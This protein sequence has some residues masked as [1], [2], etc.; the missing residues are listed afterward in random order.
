MMVRTLI[1]T[2]GILSLMSCKDKGQKENDGTIVDREKIDI[3]FG[4]DISQVQFDHLYVV[5]DSVSYARIKQ[6]DSSKNRYA[7][8][9]KGLPDFEPIDSLSTSCYLRGREHSIEL[10]G[11]DN[12]Y[13]EPIGK[14]GIGFSLRNRGEH[15]HLGV[16]PK[17][18]Q[19]DTPY[20]SISDTVQMSLGE[21]T[22]T[23]FKAFYSPGKETALIT[24]YAFYN[25]I[26]LDSL[27]RT[28]HHK[29]SRKAFLKKS[30]NQEQLF[31]GVKSIHMTCIPP[32][33][34]RIAQ[35]MRQLGCELIA[36]EG[37]T[38]TIASGDVNITITPSNSIE[39]SRINHIKCDMNAMDS[40]SI[41]LGNIT[42]TNSGTES[43]WNLENLYKNN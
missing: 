11:P 25:P 7:T 30:Y 26:F 40:S 9:D 14:S 37:N 43:V 1:G 41:I 31:E 3:I 19:A 5:L 32:D 34:H 21:N 20:L 35:E 8:I 12:K 39:Y 22:T 27:H 33:Y 42:I 10:L 29:Y 28:A 15:F 17:L 38:L 2:I 4:H 16:A 24:W 6:Y 18:K 36:K 13:G 23:W